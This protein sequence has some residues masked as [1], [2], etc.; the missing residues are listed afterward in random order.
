MKYKAIMKI[1]D[2]ELLKQLGFLV[3]KLF[4]ERD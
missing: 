3:N 4:N 1:D 2:P